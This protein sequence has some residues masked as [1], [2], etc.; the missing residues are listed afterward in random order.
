MKEQAVYGLTHIPLIMSTN[1]GATIFASG[2]NVLK[3]EI[4]ISS[5]LSGTS[6]GTLFI[7]G[8]TFPAAVSI[9]SGGMMD[10]GN[11]AGLRYTINGPAPFFIGLV[12]TTTVVNVLQSLSQT[13]GQT[14]KS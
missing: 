10:I 13:Y 1:G 6:L 9:L 11:G 8:C 2:A 4:F 12:G 3:S 5:Q 14:F 7:A